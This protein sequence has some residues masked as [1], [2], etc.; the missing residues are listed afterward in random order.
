MLSH[1]WHKYS[2]NNILIASLLKFI[3]IMKKISFLF[4]PPKG[5]KT[6]F[7]FSLKISPLLSSWE[8]D[9]GVRRLQPEREGIKRLPF[10]IRWSLQ[11]WFKTQIYTFW[12][13]FGLEPG[14]QCFC[15]GHR[16]Y[17]HR[18]P[19]LVCQC[20]IRCVHCLMDWNMDFSELGTR[21]I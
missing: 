1:I 20:G 2:R 8:S 10:A 4:T 9:V 18:G 3:I 19:I 21:E 7:F 14:Q 15:P 13:D 16:S 17:Y 5:K 6:L 12:P 11:C